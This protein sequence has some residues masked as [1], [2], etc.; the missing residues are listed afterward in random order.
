MPQITLDHL[1][2]LAQPD[3]VQE[4]RKCCGS[5]RWAQ[6]M[7]INRPYLSIED[8]CVKARDIWW[9][10]NRDDWFE[11]FRSHPRIGE[12]KPASEV[13]TQSQE[14][15]GQEQASVQ[16]AQTETLNEL[17]GLNREYETKFGFIYIVCA[18]G[19]S[20]DEM[21][22]ILKSRINNDEEDELTVAANEQA[23][24]TELRLRKMIDSQ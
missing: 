23:Q 24:I 9:D 7:V 11:A 10:L 12:K 20:S 21:L 19:K 4:F 3:A 8:L 17:A 13:S 6:R 15:S 18:T 2:T 14:W 5:H 22:E 1:N 16:T